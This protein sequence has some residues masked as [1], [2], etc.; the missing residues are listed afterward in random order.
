MLPLAF[1][2]VARAATPLLPLTPPSNQE[3]QQ[4]QSDHRANNRQT[5]DDTAA[6]VSAATAAATTARGGCATPG[7]DDALSD[8]L[9]KGTTAERQAGGAEHALQEGLL[10][11][12]GC[13]PIGG[14]RIAG[15]GQVSAELVDRVGQI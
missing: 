11:R 5:R 4:C 3:S 10:E 9:T 7:V 8:A 6:K 12:T 15:N 13:G 14:G 2:K 1:T